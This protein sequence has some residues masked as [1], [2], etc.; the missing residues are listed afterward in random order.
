MCERE[1]A[2][3]R[4]DRE[5]NSLRGHDNKYLASIKGGEFLY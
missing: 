1:R 2:S 4:E 3:E 5:E